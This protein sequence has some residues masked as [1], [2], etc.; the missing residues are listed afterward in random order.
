VTAI[1]Q[2]RYDQLVRRVNNITSPGS[3]VAD[4]LSELFPM[5]NVETNKSEL[6]LLSGTRLAFGAQNSALSV[7]EVNHAQLFNPVGSNQILTCT[8]V[9]LRAAATM[10]IRYAMSIVAL[11]NFTANINFAD[12]RSLVTGSPIGQVREVQQAGG[13]ALVGS[14]LVLANDTR[15]LQSSDG[16]FVLSPGTGITFATTVTGTASI[17]SFMWRERL[18]E[19]AELNF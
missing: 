18:A 11:T 10:E 2:N 4:S 14:Y 19:P 13:L 6:Q 16:L 8:R 17:F 9:D 7:A 3:M 15:T 12:G 1:Q 5:I